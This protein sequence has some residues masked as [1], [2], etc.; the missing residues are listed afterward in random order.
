MQYLPPLMWD[1]FF[2]GVKCRVQQV[3]TPL[4]TPFHPTSLEVALLFPPHTLLGRSTTSRECTLSKAIG[5]EKVTVHHQ[6]SVFS[7]VL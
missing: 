7:R 5:G 2:S 6:V 3:T 1:A 4:A